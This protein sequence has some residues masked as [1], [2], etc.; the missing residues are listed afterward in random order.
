MER[1]DL[2]TWKV[3][4]MLS[5]VE[6]ETTDMTQN[7]VS[8]SPREANE[9]LESVARLESA[10]IARGAYSRGFSLAIALWAGA[11]VFTIAIE[12]PF[13]LFLLI[14]GVYAAQWWRR[15]Q[16]AWIK[17]VRSG[18]GLLLAIALAL[19]AGALFIASNVA[20]QDF[21]IAWA[22]AAGGAIMTTGLFL[23][24]ESVYAPARREEFGS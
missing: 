10:G 14:A 23:L 8:P 16:G 6:S 13:F 20:R 1:F 19:P 24:M 17:E 7:P 9:A 2:P 3:S 4:S 15:R 12:S 11:L 22:P 18:R 5:E 21:G